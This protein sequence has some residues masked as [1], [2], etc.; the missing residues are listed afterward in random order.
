[1]YTVQMCGTGV[2]CLWMRPKSSSSLLENQFLKVML[3]STK[4]KQDTKNTIIAQRQKQPKCSLTDK[5]INKMCYTNSMEQFF[6]LKIEGNLDTCYN[7]DDPCRHCAKWNKP[8]THEWILYDSTYVRF[9]KSIH[10]DRKWNDGFQ[11]LGRNG[12]IS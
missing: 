4:T 11:G 9:L 5:W 12:M 8:G 7:M 1:M 10:E 3:K 6:S 2:L